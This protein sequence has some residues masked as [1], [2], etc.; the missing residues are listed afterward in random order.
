MSLIANVVSLLLFHSSSTPV[1]LADEIDNKFQYDVTGGLLAAEAVRFIAAKSSLVMANDWS[2]VRGVTRFGNVDRRRFRAKFKFTR[3][4]V[5]PP[6]VRVTSSAYRA[7]VTTSEYSSAD[8][9]AAD[10]VALYGSSSA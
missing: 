4:L 1:R 9:F 8:R 6:T 3:V 10:T 7:V 2:A 5:F